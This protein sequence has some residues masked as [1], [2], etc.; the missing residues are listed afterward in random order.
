MDEGVE[1]ILVHKRDGLGLEHFLRVAAGDEVGVAV[2]GADIGVGL[3]DAGLYE[4]TEGDE[5]DSSYNKRKK[6]QDPLVVKAG[7]G[8]TTT[9][10]T[11]TTI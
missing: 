1:F 2:E 7:V 3:A 11:T 9:T 5:F 6:Q 10:T 4:C 8:V